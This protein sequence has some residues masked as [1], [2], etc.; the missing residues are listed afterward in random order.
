MP[1]LPESEFEILS[2]AIYVPFSST[3]LIS[4]ATYGGI[5]SG[6]VYPGGVTS[7]HIPKDPATLDWNTSGATLGRDRVIA[8][9]YFLDPN[10]GKIYEGGGRAVVNNDVDSFLVEPGF[11]VQPRPRMA[12][13]YSGPPH[14]FEL[15]NPGEIW[16][17]GIAVWAK[18]RTS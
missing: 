3:D 8:A 10:S 12:T 15:Y 14:T 11:D 4:V 9:L 6:E 16:I 1:L 5:N 18:D 2:L 13:V 7:E 17:D